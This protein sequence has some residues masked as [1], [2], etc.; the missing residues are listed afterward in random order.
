MARA[1]WNALIFHGHAGTARIDGVPG[2]AAPVSI[3]FLDT[4]GSVCPSLLPSGRALDR[5]DV[6]G[7]GTVEATLIDNGMPCKMCDKEGHFSGIHPPV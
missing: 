2:T 7:L 5:I 1:R 3:A 6:P 4:A